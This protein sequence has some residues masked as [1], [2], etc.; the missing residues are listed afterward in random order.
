M[1]PARA[2]AR[3]AGSIVILLLA[4]AGAELRG[5]PPLAEVMASTPNRINPWAADA[6]PLPPVERLLGVDQQFW[7]KVGPPEASLSVSVVEPQGKSQS[8]RGTIL[9]LHGLLA[10]SAVMLPVARAL[11]GSGYRTVLVDLRGCGRSSGKYM[12]FGLQE[13]KDLSQVIDALEQKGLRA[14]GVGVYGISYGA[15][16]SIHL[17]AVDRRVRAVVAVEPFSTAREEVPHFGRVMVPGVGW[18]ISDKMYQESLDEA[19]RIAHFD[20]DEADA[21]RAIQR[22]T[23]PVLIIHGMNDWV[24]PHRQSERLHAAALDHSEL[25]SIPWLGHVALWVDPGGHVVRRAGDWFDRWLAGGGTGMGA[26]QP[27]AATI[28]PPTVT[29]NPRPVAPLPGSSAAAN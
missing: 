29:T 21:V 2:L 17:A 18:L 23:A 28:P 14:G 25:V 24:V 13:A 11:A 27:P 20:P 15:T 26:N 8:P 4:A 16:T 1:R 10:R 6:N 19:G 9:V 5:A 7:V 22:T 12:T 3:F